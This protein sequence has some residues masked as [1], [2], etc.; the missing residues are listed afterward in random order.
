MNSPLIPLPEERLKEVAH[1]FNYPPTPDVTE[2]VREHLTTGSGLRT[3]MRSAWVVVSGLL[4][5]TLAV[6]FAVPGVRA[7]ILRFFQ[8][9][10]VRIFPATNTPTV[11]PS[12]PQSP[13]TATPILA[14]PVTATPA[15]ISTPYNSQ[16]E[17]LN[18]IGI[19]GLAGETTLK[20][21]Q[22]NLPF[23]IKLPSYP[24]DLGVPERVFQQEDGSM[25]IL[26]WTDPTDS[27][28]ALLGLYEIGP[29]SVIIHKFEPRVIQET[30]VNGQYAIWVQG[31]YLVQLI[32][33]TYA[34]RMLVAGNTLIWE[35][36]N[37][38]Y[39]LESDLSLEEMIKIA[40]SVK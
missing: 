26:I 37:I 25:V 20:V 21:A 13:V 29:G 33:G 9:G 36:N 30:Q 2:A 38:T 15:L 23:P 22:T 40:E 35:D 27:Q 14:L 4:V 10:V 39:R 1:R 7:E 17:S 12:I 11:V 19:S 3:R 28:K 5:L 24:V 34:E 31:P 8:V 18:S 16:S 6:L 32:D